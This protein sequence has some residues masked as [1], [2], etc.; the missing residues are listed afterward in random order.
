MAKLETVVSADLAAWVVDTIKR[1]AF[2]G[3]AGDG[4]IFV[5]RGNR[6]SR[7]GPVRRDHRSSDMGPKE[8]TMAVRRHFY[9]IS[10]AACAVLMAEG[11][12]NA[13]APGQPAQD[14]LRAALSDFN[15]RVGEYVD[16]HRRVGRPLGEADDT[17]K[18]AEITLR[19]A[20]LAQGIRMARTTAQPGDI[21]TAQTAGIL[22]P[23]IAQIYRRSPAVRDTAQDAEAELPDFTPVVNETYPP[24]HPL[25]TFPP[26]LF[27]VLPPLPEELEYRIV[28]H[29]LILRDVEANL[30]VDVLPNAIP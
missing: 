19:E 20:A 9:W 15:K 8:R 13:P 28:T 11:C 17:R 23:A 14:D 7:S 1:A 25:G 2:T 5:I 18:P 21:F 16:L 12:R 3:R 29:H 4:K 27:K 22:K 24:T 26:T 10:L 30:I 6:P